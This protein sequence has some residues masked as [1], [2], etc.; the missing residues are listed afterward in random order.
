MRSL[1]KSFNTLMVN[2]RVEMK[3]TGWPATVAF[4]GICGVIVTA[5][6]SYNGNNERGEN[7]D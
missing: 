1:L 6:L 2:T 5:I 3:M 4:L 7:D